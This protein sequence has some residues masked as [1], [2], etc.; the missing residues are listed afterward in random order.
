MFWVCSVANHLPRLHST[1]PGSIGRQRCT[2]PEHPLLLRLLNE[3]SLELPKQ[4]IEESSS[5][6]LTGLMQVTGGIAANDMLS[7]YLH[8]PELHIWQAFWRDAPDLYTMIA[9]EV[10]CFDQPISCYTCHTSTGEDVVPLQRRR[11]ALSAFLPFGVSINEVENCQGELFVEGTALQRGPAA[12]ALQRWGDRSAHTLA[13]PLPEPLSILL[14]KGKWFSICQRFAWPRPQALLPGFPACLIDPDLEAAGEVLQPHVEFAPEKFAMLAER[15]RSW[16]PCLLRNCRDEEEVVALKMELLETILFFERAHMGLEWTGPNQHFQ[17]STLIHAVFLGALLGSNQYVRDA[18]PLSLGIALPQMDLQHVVKRLKFPKPSTIDRAGSSLDFAFLLWMRKVWE[19]SDWL[20]YAWADSSPQSG[21]EW[22]MMMHASV[23][24]DS[25]ITA[26]T[27][28]NRLTRARQDLCDH[29]EAED[30]DIEERPLLH[31]QLLQAVSHHKCVPVALGSG[32][33]SLED[34]VSA[35]LHATSFECS[36]PKSLQMHLCRFVSWT[37]DFGTEAMLPQFQS[38]GLATVLPCYMYQQLESDVLESDSGNEGEDIPKPVMPNAMLTAGALHIT[39]NASQDLHTKMAWWE[40]FW[41]HCKAVADLLVPQHLRDR[42]VARCVRGTAAAAEEDIFRKMSLP[43]LYEKRWQVVIKFM[44]TLPPH[45]RLIKQVWDFDKFKIDGKD[46]DGDVG[47][48]F[49]SALAS[50]LFCSYLFMVNG[51]HSVLSK[52]EFWLE[53]CSCHE[54]LFQNMSSKRQRKKRQALF[55]G[56]RF[57]DCPMR[58][59]RASELAAGKLEETLSELSM[60]A[61]NVFSCELDWRISQEDRVVV[62]TD[63]EYAKA[64]LHFVLVAK[65]DFW[66]KIPW[67]LCGISHHWP[68][69]ARQIAGDCLAEFDESMRMAGVL[70][71]HHHPVSLRF[72]APGGPLRTD[73]EAFAAGA[74]MS[75]HL[76]S[77]AFALKFIPVVERVV[78]ALHRDVKVASKHI[79]LGPTKVSLSVR[80]REIMERMDA[81]PDF[82][83]DLQK[84]FD[85]TRHPKQAAASLGI[86]GHPALVALR[87]QGSTDSPVWI[88]AVAHIVHRCDLETQFADMSQARR[89]HVAKRKADT[90]QAEKLHNNQALPTPR[91]YESIFKRAISDHFR[92]CAVSD[93][94]Y[95][96]PVAEPFELFP[97]LSNAEK[98]HR[99]DERQDVLDIVLDDR[100]GQRPMH[101]DL[102]FRLLHGG[103]SRMKAMQ[104]PV[105]TAPTFAKDAFVIAAHTINNFVGDQPHVNM[106]ARCKPQVLQALE[107]CSL[108][109]LRHEFKCW[110]LSPG[111][112]YALPGLEG[113]DQSSVT[114]WV[115]RLITARALPGGEPVP[116]NDLPLPLCQTL[117]Q[118]GFLER[119]NLRGGGHIALS[120]A[121]LPKIQMVGA[122]Q[123]PMQVC[124]IGTKKIADYDLMEF[125]SALELKGWSW[126]PLPPTTR[127][128]EHLCHEPGGCLEWYSQ[129]HVINKAYLQCLLEADMLFAKGIT[130]IPHWTKQPSV[131]YPKL[132]QGKMPE[133]VPHM[134]PL[135]HDIPQDQLQ[136]PAPEPEQAAD[137]SNALGDADTAAG[138]HELEGDDVAHVIPVPEVLAASAD[139]VVEVAAAL[140]SVE[141]DEDA[142]PAEAPVPSARS[143]DSGSDDSAV[144]KLGKPA[145]WGPFKLTV[146][147]PAAGR[148]FGGVEATCPFHRRNAK[149]GCKKYLQLRSDSQDEFQTCIRSL[150][151]W[152]NAATMYSRQ[153]DHLSHFVSIST[154]PAQEVLDAGF[155]DQGPADRPPGDDELD[156]AEGFAAAPKAKPKAGRGR[157]KAAPKAKASHARGRGRPGWCIACLQWK[158]TIFVQCRFDFSG[159]TCMIKPCFLFD[160]V[161]RVI[162]VSSHHEETLFWQGSCSSSCCR[163]KC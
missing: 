147:Q 143:D 39:H 20:H 126:K 162:N 42:L 59:K 47:A 36:T 38:K 120:E 153:R 24:R 141:P 46:A 146:K 71:E 95:S 57:V 45:F 98:R 142:I 104:M 9:K 125:L 110:K 41:G 159:I 138:R 48:A 16:G 103:P 116:M 131:V 25:V 83:P 40:N 132:L 64:H 15:V 94:F 51:I 82:L 33:V 89:T 102:Y 99:V 27:A 118:A 133:A 148:L 81:D 72:L 130:S 96:L 43:A 2:L 26:C 149:T 80:L 17:S 22:F 34:K 111:I 144:P 73:L 67:R 44:R 49:D 128:R 134:L 10:F 87:N 50:P 52:L 119:F 136:L 115:T 140:E 4:R 79:K 139:N 32:K 31:Q 29:F 30:V 69:V 88:R 135:E 56:G 137:I 61:L 13:L 53:D 62:L 100:E 151:A 158:T 60:T 154:A 163:F 85:L 124:S 97:V 108:D 152:C 106:T 8:R 5:F 11:H 155:I 58:G 113:T 160:G 3:N 84:V 76:Q 93:C 91:T 14:L 156:A 112:Q 101:G 70:E 92:A 6:S 68:S 37:T 114:K 65:F 75:E 150:K 129:S 161:D 90:S 35:L 74:P 86:F 21:R 18:I 105:A 28:A 123:D 55:G 7:H 19:S 107:S 157:G 121:A 117:F 122:L 66:Q 1:S 127:A 145:A 77:E 109:V 78:E 23:L 54:H 63:F 12:L